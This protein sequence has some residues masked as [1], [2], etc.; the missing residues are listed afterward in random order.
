MRTR[1][2]AHR[3]MIL[4][5]FDADD[6]S[7]SLD[8]DDWSSSPT[9][10]YL[11]DAKDDVSV[12]PWQVIRPLSIR[13]KAKAEMEFSRSLTRSTERLNGKKSSR[14]HHAATAWGWTADPWAR[15]GQRG[16][17]PCIHLQH[18]SS[19]GASIS[20]SHSTYVDFKACKRLIMAA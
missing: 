15:L 10:R 18:H 14:L 4:G 6:W 5:L 19:K 17:N 2:I 8:A 1:S 12:Q 20:A 13:S 16:I 3:D 9:L 11:V 7:S